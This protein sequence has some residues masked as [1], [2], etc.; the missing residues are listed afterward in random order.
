MK[1]VML[2]IKKYGCFFV[3]IGVLLFISCDPGDNSNIIPSPLD[4]LNLAKK[5]VDELNRYNERSNVEEMFYLKKIH[6]ISDTTN[7]YIVVKD[8]HSGLYNAYDLNKYTQGMTY[9][10]FIKNAGEKGVIDNLFNNQDGTFTDRFNIEWIF[11]DTSPSTKDLEKIGALKDEMKIANVRE[12][13]AADFGL[14]EERSAQIAKLVLQWNKLEKRRAMTDEDVRAFSKELL[15]VDL[16]TALNAY[17][18]SL[19]GDKHELDLFIKKASE[20]NFITPE[21]MQLI[22]NQIVK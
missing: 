7:N 14:S 11:E 22:L 6:G 18:K 3:L 13:L 15:G 16:N 19:Q 12:G 4:R 2:M 20:A 17:K 10:A 5:F 9:D 8:E 1:K 21:K